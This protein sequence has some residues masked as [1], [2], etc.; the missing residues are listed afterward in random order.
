MNLLIIGGTGFFGK[1]TLDSFIRGLLLKHEI[2]IITV[3]S[4]SADKFQSK[5]PEFKDYNIKYIKADI[6]SIDELPFADI[7]IH[8]ATSTKQTDYLNNSFEE[9]KNTEKG[10]SNYIKLAKKFHKNSKIIYC[11]SGAVY[12]K[13]PSNVSNIKEDFPFQ[14]L[15]KMPVL[16]RDYSRLQMRLMM[17]CRTPFNTMLP[18]RRL[19][20]LTK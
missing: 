2:S 3:L 7:I 11:S 17:F 14:D 19:I 20:F 18:L 5:H 13:Q 6:S 10:V 8:A 4:R 1:S 12:G 9:I 15:D 16:K